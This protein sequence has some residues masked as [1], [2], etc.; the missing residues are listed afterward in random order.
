VIH[1]GV[2]S[3]PAAS[4][5]LTRFRDGGGTV[6][7]I[8]NAPRPGAQV[9]RL[10]DHL[11]VPRSAYDA[12]VTSGDVTRDCV[13]RRAGE[14]VFHIG[15]ERDLT[16]FTGLD[17]PFGP[18]ETARYVIC[19]GLYDDEVETPDDYR[20]LIGKIR[21]RNLFMVCANPDIVVE[22]GHELVYCAGAIA[23]LYGSLGGDVLYANRRLAEMLA[24]PLEQLI[25]SSLRE[26]IRNVDEAVL[27]LCLERARTIPQKL[28]CDLH[29]SDGRLLPVNLSLSP[30]QQNDF[31]GICVIAT[32]LTQQKLREGALLWRELADLIDHPLGCRERRV[33]A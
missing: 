17:A 7:L 27:N 2:E 26:V 19:S 24:T 30:M 16:I 12:I 11:H 13:G 20:E 18:L 10:L 9:T 23:D 3:F 28:A 25:S 33:A 22:R 14:P 8:S 15:P 32:D 5:A 29:I 4:E 6:C 31:R 1:N 21:A